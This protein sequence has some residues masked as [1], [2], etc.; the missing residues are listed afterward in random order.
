MKIYKFKFKRKADKMR[1]ILESAPK[2][3]RNKLHKEA[4]E[5]EQFIRVKRLMND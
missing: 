1:D 5:F 2:P 3:D 4:K